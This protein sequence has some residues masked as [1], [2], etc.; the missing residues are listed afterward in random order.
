MC[1]CIGVNVLLYHFVINAN[2]CTIC[3]YTVDKVN[4]NLLCGQ[5]VW[6]EPSTGARMVPA[7]GQTTK[8]KK[9]FICRFGWK[10]F[11]SYFKYIH[12]RAIFCAPLLGHIRYCMYRHSRFMDIMTKTC[13]DGIWI[14][15]NAFKARLMMFQATFVNISLTAK[16]G[17]YQDIDLLVNSGRKCYK[18]LYTV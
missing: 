6:S 9:S 16:L 12:S 13:C 7:N 5:E 18:I 8:N 15:R 1:E 3:T 2:V 4:L 14:T 10:A 11:P 17:Q